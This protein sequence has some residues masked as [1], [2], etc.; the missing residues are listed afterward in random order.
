[1]AP[2]SGCSTPAGQVNKLRPVQFQLPRGLHLGQGWAEAAE[3]RKP[4]RGCEASAGLNGSHAGW[5][6]QVGWCPML[7]GHS[8]AGQVARKA[9][10]P[11]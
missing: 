2:H 9:N 3:G 8:Q 10:Q 11:L 7:S 5:L 4:M 6:P 1:M